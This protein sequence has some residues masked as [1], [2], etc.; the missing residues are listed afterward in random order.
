MDRRYSAIEISDVVDQ[1]GAAC[2]GVE[3]VGVP[4]ND[5]AEI[6]PWLDE[7]VCIGAKLTILLCWRSFKP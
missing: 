1:N 7:S 6:A 3:D 5:N 4:V 2:Y